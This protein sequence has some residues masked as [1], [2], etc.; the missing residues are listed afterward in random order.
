MRPR[1]LR[2][3]RRCRRCSIAAGRRSPGSWSIGRS[4]SICRSPSATTSPPIRGERDEPRRPG[5]RTAIARSRRRCGR[6]TR[7]RRAQRRS[8]R[9]DAAARLRALGYV[10]G[11]AAAEGALHGRRRSEDARRRRS[12]R[13]RCGRCV[14]ARAGRRSDADLSAGDRAAARHGDRLP[15][16]RVHRAA[17]RQRR[18][19]AIDVLQRAIEGG[20]HRSAG[21]GQLGEYLTE[22]GQ[23]ADGDSRC[24]NR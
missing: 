18:R 11:T 21:V 6:S 24:S 9:A 7:R 14:R 19:R 8:K 16:S 23:I 12:C 13:A 3:S 15:A 4:T 5:R 2:T 22:S 10:S 20:R 1:G 17:A